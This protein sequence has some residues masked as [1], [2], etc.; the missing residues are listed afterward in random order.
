[1][2]GAG[3]D[4]REILASLTT[5]PAERFGEAGRRGSVTPG[6]D[7]D[8]VVLAADPAVD[9]K[10]YAKVRY[11]IRGGRIVYPSASEVSP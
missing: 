8:I 5:A 4:W 9:V 2:A 1:M 11:T 10:A 3:L 7:A 6:M